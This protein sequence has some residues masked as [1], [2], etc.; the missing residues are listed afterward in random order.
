MRVPRE[1]LFHLIE[2]LL[3]HVEHPARYLDHE[4][5]SVQE[6]D[7]PFH[8][9][10]VYADVYE[11]GQP[12]LG[13][14]ILYNAVNDQPGMSCERGYLPWRDMAALMRER[15]V[16][17]LSLEGA[18]PLASFDAIGFTLAHELIATNVLEALDLA[19]IAL[20]SDQ[21]TIPSL[22]TKSITKL[23]IQNCVSSERFPL[24]LR[25]STNRFA[26]F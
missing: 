12:N 18:A 24:S 16:P 11:V 5:G 3:A 4:W 26:R 6:Q 23:L 7:G 10:M 19:G 8:L 2:P 25:F 20:R 21:W 1:N 9:C 14:A 15:G 22:S 17:L 13:V